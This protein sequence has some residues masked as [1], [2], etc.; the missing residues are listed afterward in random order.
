MKEFRRV[1]SFFKRNFQ[2]TLDVVYFSYCL[3]RGWKMAESDMRSTVIIMVAKAVVEFRILPLLLKKKKKKWKIR[4]SST[5]GE[6]PK[7]SL[8]IDRYKYP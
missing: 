7:P 3:T 4:G 1:S 2:I 8:M 6:V 5:L